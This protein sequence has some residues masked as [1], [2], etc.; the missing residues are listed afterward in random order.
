MRLFFL[1]LSIVLPLA[2][3]GC[4]LFYPVDAAEHRR[5]IWMSS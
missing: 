1:E 3:T 2:L 5:Q 4:L